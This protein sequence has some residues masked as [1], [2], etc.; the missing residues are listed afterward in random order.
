M[1]ADRG[2][3]RLL[4]DQEAMITHE[5]LVAAGL[6]GAGIQRRVRAG[7]LR[8]MH[9]GVYLAGP[10]IPPR[11]EEMAA[12]LACGATAHVSHE[13]AAYLHELP[14]HPAKP[15]PVHVTVEARHVRRPNI[16]THKTTSLP[17]DE[18]THVGPVPTTTAARAILDLAASV[19]RGNLERLIAEAY[20]LKA[21]SEG[22][23]RKLALRHRPRRGSAVL[24]ALLDDERGPQITDS[25]AE[26]R[27]LT[28]VRA[29]HLPEPRAGVRL[30]GYKVDFLWPAHRLVVEVDGYRFHSSAARFRADRKRDQELIARGYTVIR[31]AWSH[32]VDEPEAL[33]ARLAA[34]LALAA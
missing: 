7:R 33:V 31:V 11:G 34:A 25:E 13:S 8:A 24:L 19:G 9:H 20:A 14:P 30:H 21:A 18:R 12:A 15:T 22:E 32:I 4:A 1:T 17:E 29:A 6:S 27:F 5:Q 23:L 16:R 28:L 10:V 2:I 26:R 3:A